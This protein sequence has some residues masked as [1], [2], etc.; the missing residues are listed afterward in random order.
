MNSVETPQIL[1]CALRRVRKKTKMKPALIR[2]G[3]LSEKYS[4]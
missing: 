1:E 3:D 2:S 4:R